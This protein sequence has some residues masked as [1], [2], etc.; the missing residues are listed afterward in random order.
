[1][2]KYKLKFISLTIV[3]LSLWGCEVNENV[4]ETENTNAT[5]N[6]FVIEPETDYY[7]NNK[8][9]NDHNVVKAAASEAW[10]ITYDFSKK[11]VLI[12]KSSNDLEA[13]KNTNP[14][15]KEIYD[16]K[17]QTETDINSKSS[18]T[19]ILTTDIPNWTKTLMLRYSNTRTSS[20][21]GQP[22]AIPGAYSVSFPLVSTNNINTDVAS[23]GMWVSTSSGARSLSNTDIGYLKIYNQNTYRVERNE[24]DNLT[25]H[26][27][28]NLRVAYLTLYGDYNQTTT[29]TKPSVTFIIYA[30]KSQRIY[31]DLYP[32]CTYPNSLKVN[33]F[34]S[35]KVTFS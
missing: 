22:F 28:D 29:T 32:R 35:Y 27:V 33:E 7:I 4:K 11:R 20:A 10:N 18:A 24:K 6:N 3:A 13:Y 23:R 26:N 19:T 17:P 8:L 1:M 31:N 5:K 16:G 2:K 25:L 21:D 30:G 15:I 12:F 14:K 9:I 34:Y